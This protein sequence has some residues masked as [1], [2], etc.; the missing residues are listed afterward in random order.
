M[1]ETVYRWLKFNVVG[2]AG[3]L[4]QL[5]TLA[6]LVTGF[7]LN[8]MPAA[9]LAVETAVLHNFIWHERWTWADRTKRGH[10]ASRFI[11][12]NLSNGAI[13]I[14]G[15]LLMMHFLVTRL[16]LPYIAA[17]LAAIGACSIFNFLASDLLFADSLK[18]PGWL[19]EFG[20]R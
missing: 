19:P 18:K 14:A 12:F 20:R 10:V 11:Q 7:G 13:S 17:N 2:V 6:V 5:V 16:H 9:V 15:N 8:Y 3:V 1:I 4:V